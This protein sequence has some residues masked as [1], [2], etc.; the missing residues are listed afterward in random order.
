MS[1]RR[2]KDVSEFVVEFAPSYQ[3]D[4]TS[5]KIVN[6]AKNLVKCAKVGHP[7]TQQNITDHLC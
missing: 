1:C 5:I 4:K 2:N 6:R 3:T 7:R